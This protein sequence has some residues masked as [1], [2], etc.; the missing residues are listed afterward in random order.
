MKARPGLTLASGS[1]DV[2]LLTEGAKA[3]PLRSVL[4]QSHYV[5]LACLELT[6]Q[7]RL[8]L[9]H[10]PPSASQVLGIQACI[11]MYLRMIFKS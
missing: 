9:G 5:C 3:Y 2:I 7:T 10:P 8:A 1:T 4:R 11:T 6:I